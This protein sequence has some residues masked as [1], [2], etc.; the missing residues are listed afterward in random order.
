MRE[1]AAV[2]APR[3][4]RHDGAPLPNLPRGCGGLSCGGRRSGGFTLRQHGLTRRKTTKIGAYNNTITLSPGGGSAAT[5]GRHG[6]W[7]TV[8]NGLTWMDH[9]WM[10]GWMDGAGEDGQSYGLD[11]S[12]MSEDVRARK[13]AKLEEAR[14]VREARGPSLQETFS[15]R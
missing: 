6:G 14:K 8:V 10:D 7:G 2:H 9:R 1:T 5:D 11:M 3:T 12:H 13:A 4:A 15:D